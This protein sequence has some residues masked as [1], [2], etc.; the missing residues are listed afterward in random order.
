MKKNYMRKEN[1]LFYVALFFGMVVGLFGS[2][3]I[4]WANEKTPEDMIVDDTFL[5]E[6]TTLTKES[7]TEP[8]TDIVQNEENNEIESEEQ[9]GKG[10]PNLNQTVETEENAALNEEENKDNQ[11]ED[12]EEFL[13]LEP[14]DNLNSEESFVEN[15]ATNSGWNEDKTQYYENGQLCHGLINI[16]GINYFFDENTG[17]LLTGIVD[18]SSNRN[19]QKYGYFDDKGVQLFGDVNI[20]GSWY[21]FD[22]A[23]GYMQT[24]FVQTGD[25]VRYYDNQGKLKTGTFRIGDIEVT[26][27]VS[28]KVVKTYIY[29]IPYLNQTDP[30]WGSLWVGSLGN[31]ASTGCVP[32]VAASVINYYLGTNYT[33]N[34]IGALLHSR[35]LY[36]V[37]DLYG[38]SSDAW[39]FLANYFGFDYKNA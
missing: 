37:G 23:T 32:T 33:P 25:V 6:T 14:K 36:N 34:D 24:G 15:N 4:V 10:V 18:L 29:N 38:S 26:T 9:V 21:Y 31:I 35:G 28:G 7:S 27:D 39:K 30:R 22:T 19:E 1:N 5:D 17:T 3:S 16:D 13:P 8:S 11:V 12:E 20:A 2:T